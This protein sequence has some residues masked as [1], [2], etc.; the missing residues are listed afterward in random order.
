[1][2]TLSLKMTQAMQNIQLNGHIPAQNLTLRFVSVNM[3]AYTGKSVEVELPFLNS[4]QVH[5]CAGNSRLYLPVNNGSTYM[6]HCAFDSDI[7]SETFEV[8]IYDDSGNLVNDEDV[9]EVLLGFE[10]QLAS[11]F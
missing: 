11:L 8:G 9:V 5:N 6:P 7:V 3:N 2:P 1:M 4:F 10:Y